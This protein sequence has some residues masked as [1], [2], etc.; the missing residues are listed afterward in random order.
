[1]PKTAQG[2]KIDLSSWETMRDVRQFT[3]AQR[4]GDLGKVFEACAGIIKEWEFDGDPTDP[5][6]YDDLTPQQWK[7]TQAEVNKAVSAFFQG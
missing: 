5:D 6:A 1:M 2:W 3:D 4:S 7:Q